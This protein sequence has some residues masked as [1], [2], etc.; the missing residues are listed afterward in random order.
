MDEHHVG[1]GRVTSPPSAIAVSLER[2]IETA[3]LGS[4]WLLIVFHLG[5]IVSLT[6]LIIKFAQQAWETLV[7]VFT[8]SGKEVILAILSLIDFTLIAQLLFI[9]VVASYEG[10]VSRLDVGSQGVRLG[11]MSQVGFEGVKLKLLG[12]LVAISGIYFIEKVIAIERVDHPDAAWAAAAFTLFVIAWALL[13]L[14]DQRCR[15][16]Q[17]GKVPNE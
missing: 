10:F 8:L 1:A 9:V 5:L 6:I 3:I 14:V 15:P 4:R 12:S 7:Q 11:W 16:S 2:L 17:D 13:A